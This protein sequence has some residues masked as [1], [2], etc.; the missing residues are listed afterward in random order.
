MMRPKAALPPPLSGELERCLAAA[1][2]G[3]TGGGTV[4]PEAL[5]AALAK[6]PGTARKVLDSLDV[7]WT[8][9]R[10]GWLL[11]AG[12]SACGTDDGNAMSRVCAFHSAH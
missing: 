3:T 4:T 8:V 9:R 1:V 10:R 5:L 2:A 6:D 12:V 11:C 7:T